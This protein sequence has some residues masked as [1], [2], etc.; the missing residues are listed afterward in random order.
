MEYQQLGSDHPMAN[1]SDPELAQPCRSHL[2]YFKL[3][4]ETPR[5]SARPCNGVLGIMYTCIDNLV[6]QSEMIFCVRT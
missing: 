2:T 5:E 4:T 3:V 1:G 6:C